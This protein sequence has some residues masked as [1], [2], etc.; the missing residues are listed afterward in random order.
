MGKNCPRL[1][2]N[3]LFRKSETGRDCP[4][5]KQPH[6]QTKQSKGGGKKTHS[7]FRDELPARE[8]DQRNVLRGRSLSPVEK[9]GN[10]KGDDSA[11]GTVQP[12]EPAPAQKGQRGGLEQNAVGPKGKNNRALKS[13]DTKTHQTKGSR[14]ATLGKWVMDH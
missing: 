14:N 12:P 6:R 10:H 1:G 13:L 2:E 5:G 8:N 4:E 11:K 3:H 9:G 7:K